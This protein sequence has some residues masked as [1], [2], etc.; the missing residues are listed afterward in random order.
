[1]NRKVVSTEKAP[2]AVGPYSQAVK[3]GGTLYCSGQIALD[4]ETGNLV[5]ESFADEARRVLMNLKAVIEEADMELSHAVKCTLYVTDISKFGEVNEVYGE[6]F[7][8]SLP[9]RA[10]V[11][12]SALPKGA[13][14]MIDCVA[15]ES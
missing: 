8:E 3:A 13:R 12:V 14:V 2:G 9:A 7:G 5:G 1:M 15:A 11:E 6:F 4:P 10:A